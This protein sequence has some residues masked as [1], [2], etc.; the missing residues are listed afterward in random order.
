MHA[1]LFI[2]GG[3]KSRRLPG[4]DAGHELGGLR[5]KHFKIK[6]LCTTI[7]V[8]DKMDPR[9]RRAEII[10]ESILD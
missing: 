9:G 8:A 6:C 7:E 2:A 4:L 5:G 3:R 10:H 1:N